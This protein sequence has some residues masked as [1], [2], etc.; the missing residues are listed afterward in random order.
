M[1][2]KIAVRGPKPRVVG[3]GIRSG[4]PASQARQRLAYLDLQATRDG[5]V[6]SPI[7]HL[8]GQIA[9]AG[10]VG[11]RLVVR[12]SVALS[13]AEIGHQPGRRIAQMDRNW[14]V[15]RVLDI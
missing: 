7:W 8:I 13:I 6:V 4:G 9:L 2:E 1:V 11:L 12:V 14:I 3:G 15:P 10:R 5:A